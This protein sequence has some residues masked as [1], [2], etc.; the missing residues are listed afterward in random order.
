MILCGNDRQLGCGWLAPGFG[1]NKMR[2]LVKEV[3]IAAHFPFPSGAMLGRQQ[4]K[5]ALLFNIRAVATV[6]PHVK[7]FAD[8]KSVGPLA[9]HSAQPK[10]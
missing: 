6:S 3:I 5:R 4:G 7:S 1:V 2:K 8:F 9:A 10:L